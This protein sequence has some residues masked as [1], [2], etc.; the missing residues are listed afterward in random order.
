MD[1]KLKLFETFCRTLAI[2]RYTEKRALDSLHIHEVY[3][4]ECQDNH[5]VDL[6]L[7]LKVFDRVNSIFLA[8]DIA[9]CIAKGSAFRFQGI[10]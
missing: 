2:F 9:Q 6:A 4:D 5:I 8:G 10:Y 7:I 1:F 3:V